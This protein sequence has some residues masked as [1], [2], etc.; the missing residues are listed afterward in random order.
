MKQ[1][2]IIAKN[3]RVHNLKSVSLTLNAGQLIVFSGVS[4]SGKSSLAFDTIFAEGQRRYVESLSTYARRYIGSLPKPDAEVIEGLSPTISIEQKT[5]GKNPRSTVGTITGIYDFLRVL[6]ARI[7]IAHC[8]ESGEEVRPQSTET[9]KRRILGMKEGTKLVVLAPYVHDKKG[10]LKDELQ[11]ITRKGFIRVRLDGQ[12]TD[13]SDPIEVDGSVSHSIDLVVDRIVLTKD[14][15]PR[16]AE[17]ITTALELGQGM[18][19]LLEADSMQETLYSQN[20][21]APT[22]KKSYPPLEPHNFSFNHP[23]GMCPECEGLGLTQTFDLDKIIDPD[24]SIAEGCCSVG[25]QFNTVKYSNIYTNLATQYDFDVHAKWK[26]LPKRAQKIFLEGVRKKYVKMRFVH[27]K[28]GK[29]WLEYVRWHGVLSEAKQRYLEATSDSYKNKMKELMVED[30]CPSCQGARIGAYAAATT[31][32]GKTIHDVTSLSVDDAHAFISSLSLSP[33]EK[34]IG[35]ELIKEITE[36]LFFLKNVGL[37]YLSIERIS[38]TLSGGEAQRVRLASQ[39][40]SGL[41]GATYVLDEPSIGLHP[42]DNTKLIDTLLDLREKGNTVIVVE[43]DEE[44]LR[45]ADHIV[46]VGPYAGYLGGEIVAEGTLQDILKSKR[47][48]TGQYLSGAKEL[49]ISDEKR[50]I[51][52]KHA[53]TIR[54]ASHHNL[55]NVDVTIPL[56]V[57]VCVT[58]VSGS[59]KSSLITDILYP[60]LANELHRA[61][62]RIGAHK[63][64]EGID[65]VD[66]VIAIDQAP[67]GRTPRSNPSTYVK[68]FDDIRD[69]FSETQEAKANGYTPGR[70]SF[71]V[72]EG[73]CT[74]CRGMGQVRVDMDFLDDVFLTCP[75]CDGKRFDT[76]TLSVLYKGKTIHDILEMTIE[77]ASEF[78]KPIPHIRKKL[79]VLHQ[80]GL[81]YIA[82]GQS[83]TTLSGGEAQRIKLA[84]ELMRPSTGQTLYILDEP[85]TG[86]HFHDIGKLILILQDLVAQGNT[87]LLIEHNTD[88]M[89]AADWIIDLGPEGGEG[90]GT[91]IGEGTPAE[92]AKQK[93][94]TGLALSHVANKSTHKKGRS[95]PIR[96]ISVRGATQNTLKGIDATVPRGKITVCT[97]PSG[98][99][100]SSFAFDTIYAEGQRRYTDALSPYARQ[101]IK[102][103]AKP[104]VSEITGLSPAIAIEQKHHAGNPRSTIG[105]ITEVH[106]YLRVLFARMGI[107]HC[108]ETG[109][110]IESITKEYVVRHIMQLPEKTKLHILAPIEGDLTEQ[111]AKLMAQGYMRIRLNNTYYEL[112]DEIPYSRKKK[113]ESFLVIDRMMVK[114]GIEKRLHESIEQATLFSSKPF[115]IATETEDLL[116]NLAFAVPSTGKTYPTITPHTFSFNADDGMCPSCQGLGFEYGADL[117]GNEE[118]MRLSP[119]QL[120]DRLWKEQATGDAFDLMEA[121]C[122]EA[123]IDA[124]LAL[125]KQPAK[126]LSMILNGETTVSFDGMEITYRGINALF[127]LIGKAGKGKWRELVLPQL[128]TT[129]CMMCQGKRL[130]PLALNVTINTKSIADV[131]EMPL[132]SALSFIEKLTVEPMLEET[133]RQLIHRL[134]F[135]VKIGLEYLSLDRMAPSLSGGEAQRI[136]LARQLGSKLTG[137]LYVLDEPTIGLHPYNNE[138]LNESL[139]ELTTLDNTLLLVEHDPLTISIADKV[140]DFGPKAGTEGGEIVAKGTYEEICHNPESRTGMYLSGTVSVPVPDKRRSAKR[141]VTITNANEHNLKALDIEIPIGIFT[142]ITGVSGSGKSTLVHSIILPAV[143]RALSMRPRHDEVTYKGATLTGVS[144]FDK[145]IALSQD[146]IG[147]TNR[148]DINTYSGLQQPLRQLFAELNEAKVRGLQ[149]KHFSYNHLK[150]MCRTCWGLGYKIV[151]LQF[152]PPVRVTCDAC[153]GARLNPVSSNVAYKGKNIGSILKMTVEDAKVFLPPHPKIIAILDTLIS[154]GLGYLTLGQEVASLSGGEAQR[155]RLTKELAKRSTGKTLYLFDE[156]TIGLHPDDTIKLLNIFHRLV[157]HGNTV[158]VIEH[159]LDVLKNADHLIDLGPGAGLHGGEIVATGTPESLASHP[160]SKTAPY[161]ASSLQACQLC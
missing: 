46:D 26:D 70:F 49:P 120:V 3:V 44:M 17:A 12:I 14:N 109:E 11:E 91:I 153:N 136:H 98:S 61:E 87:V 40:G 145:V 84:K 148:A 2:P 43:H 124:D 110:V 56:S 63:E 143:K 18:L 85:T 81:G 58:G 22:S 9:I 97:G 36:R 121:V 8:P 119:M 131:C 102:Q 114:E 82:L 42:R 72:L 37:G 152:L 90:G 86:L 65:Q 149:P 66:K 71:N 107:P 39:I 112:D 111:K 13:L 101:F 134:S 67:I 155:L 76:K 129:T 88:V 69:L 122:E 156:P 32:F 75:V 77:E 34:L 139:K 55:K 99:G 27:P 33:D 52:K 138:R 137:C 1:Q 57:F 29:S 78:F 142:T 118:L 83:S 144:H 161:L 10:E 62:L 15:H 6:F 79:E 147:H 125:S 96:E 35:E 157:L 51:Q 50:P 154:V 133:K 80:V 7:G 41:V 130:K 24:K 30:T 141:F 89:R 158:I 28:T 140:I 126:A 108:P 16:L 23:S 48:L 127:G 21:Y 132:D 150:G 45:A 38:P 104:K 117:L 116:F 159:N 93:S 73:S 106:D 20:A 64:I 53:L 60:K 100:K 128:S 54:G 151:R 113:N 59:G 146:P 94:P 31:F 4:G 47:S 115:T 5:I 95:D 160:T 92:I 74:N 123:G 105:T 135:L 103:M 25:G 68:L 19:I